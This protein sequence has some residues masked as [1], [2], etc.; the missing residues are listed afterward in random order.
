M[1]EKVGLLGPETTRSLATLVQNLAKEKLIL[2]S[3]IIK[4]ASVS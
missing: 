3:V 2:E 1:P 4:T